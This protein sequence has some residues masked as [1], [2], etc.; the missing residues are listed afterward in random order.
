MR[1]NGWKKWTLFVT[2]CGM[3]LQVATC[4][5]AAQIVTG[6]ATAITAGSAVVLVHKILK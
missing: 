3:L 5:Q 2:G 4:S 6:W 1:P